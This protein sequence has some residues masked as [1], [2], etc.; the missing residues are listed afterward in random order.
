MSKVR[1]EPRTRPTAARNDA[2]TVFKRAWEVYMAGA[3][4]AYYYTYTS[5]DVVRVNDTPTGYGV[6]QEPGE[7]LQPGRFV[8]DGTG[9]FAGGHRPLPGQPGSGICRLPAGEEE[10]SR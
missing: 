1:S 2:V 4:G 6:L 10:S 3:Y 9:G 8:A 7:V 5:W